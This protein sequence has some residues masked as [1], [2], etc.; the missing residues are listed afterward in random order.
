ML[1]PF[2]LSDGS[3]VLLATLKWLTPD[4]HEIWHQG[5][6][7]DVEVALKDPSAAL[8]PEM[9]D[10][11]SPAAFQKEGD[12]QLLKALDVLRGQGGEKEQAPGK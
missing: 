5:I 1:Q 4:G 2:D 11:L 6:K 3:E 12:A 7:P 9:E 8:L 10:D